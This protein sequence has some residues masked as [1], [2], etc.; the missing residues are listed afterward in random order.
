MLSRPSDSGA[1][2]LGLP[3]TALA[4][5]T[6]GVNSQ[7]GLPLLLI[8]RTIL[9]ST[10]ITSL[11]AIEP[12]SNAASDSFTVTDFTSTMLGF[13]EPGALKNF[14]PLAVAAGAGSRA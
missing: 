14:R 3:A 4:S 8:S 6:E 13:L 12:V 2:A 5:A 9:G 11:T 10:R 7:L 1:G